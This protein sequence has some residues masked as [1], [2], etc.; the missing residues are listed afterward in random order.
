MAK[1]PRR[2]RFL[3]LSQ[4]EQSAVLSAVG[5]VVDAYHADPSR[6]LAEMTWFAEFW[7]SITKASMICEL[8]PPGDWRRFQ[9][10]MAGRA[11]RAKK[12]NFDIQSLTHDDNESG[13]SN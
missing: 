11:H 12:L 13:G 9:N 8:F 3:I 6:F 1:V 7:A 10:R 5:C 4:D 2:G